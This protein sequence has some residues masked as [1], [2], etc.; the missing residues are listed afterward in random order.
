LR[1]ENAVLIQT[2]SYLLTFFAMQT[3]RDGPNCTWPFIHDTG[4]E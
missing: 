4:G 2:T 3:G 1:K